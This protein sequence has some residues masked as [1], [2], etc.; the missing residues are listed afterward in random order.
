MHLFLFLDKKD[1][2]NNLKKVDE[3][4]S[5]EIPNIDIYQKLYNTRNA[6]RYTSNLTSRPAASAAVHF[7]LEKVTYFIKITQRERSRTRS[8]ISDSSLE[9]NL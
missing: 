7:T 5:A 6:R 3:F 8:L 1:K 4:I 9:R 2:I